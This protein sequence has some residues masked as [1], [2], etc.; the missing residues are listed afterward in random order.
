MFE[1]LAKGVNTLI[2]MHKSINCYQNI[3]LE[4]AKSGPFD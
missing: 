3:N 1:N 4:L 2:G